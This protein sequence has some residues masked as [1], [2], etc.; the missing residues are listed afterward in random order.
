GDVR[1]GRGSPVSAA[2]VTPTEVAAAPVTAGAAPVATGAAPVTASAA[3]GVTAETAREAG[4]QAP[5]GAHRG[6]E[7]GADEHAGEQ[8]PA[9]AAVVAVGVRLVGRARVPVRPAVAV[10]DDLAHLRG[11]PA[12]HGVGVGRAGGDL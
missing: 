8:V 10:H 4:G 7:H 1:A 11:E 2:E 6:A 5:A 9:E 12:L 3:A